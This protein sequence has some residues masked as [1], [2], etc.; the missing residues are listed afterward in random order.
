MN[1][2]YSV[3]AEIR[4]TP[5]QKATWRANAADRGISFSDFAR[6]V[7]DDAPLPRAN[8]AAESD[9]RLRELVVLI[10]TRQDQMHAQ[11]IA[12]GVTSLA[13]AAYLAE[14][15]E[16]RAIFRDHFDGNSHDGTEESD[17]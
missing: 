3:T 1:S 12:G 4:C 13:I 7:L 17:E 5:E 9:Q 10:C 16:L 8:Q 2:Q 11:L 14:V 6:I 15:I